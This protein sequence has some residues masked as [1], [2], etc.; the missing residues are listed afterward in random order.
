MSLF[1]GPWILLPGNHDPIS[2]QCIWTRVNLLP[3]K[4]DNIILATK[5]EPINLLDGRLI[6]LPA[7]LPYKHVY[8]DLTEWF[9]AYNVN[10]ESYKVGLAHGAVEGELFEKA[11]KYN[12]ISKNRVETARLDYLALGDWHGMYKISPRIFY[13]GTPE[14]DR[15]RDNNTG[16]A[17]LVRLYK[18]HDPEIERIPI[19][20]YRWFK[21]DVKLYQQEDV[22]TLNNYFNSI[23]SPES[24]IIKL[25]IQGLLSLSLRHELNMVLE[26]WNARLE[27]LFIVDDQLEIKQTDHEITEMKSSGFIGKV[28]NTLID[29]KENSQGEEKKH[30][31]RAIQILWH[32]AQK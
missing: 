15:F 8:N 22:S 11:E 24:V 17:L 5:P 26:K 6:I 18:G 21:H 27:Y 32:E 19:G 20:K 7:P 25:N 30:A 14:Q 31:E 9:D 12:L 16:N 10:N 13:S 1:K 28:F 4:T 29:Y 3:E 2:E 23:Q